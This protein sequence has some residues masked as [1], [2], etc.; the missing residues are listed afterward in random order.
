MA[1][2]QPFSGIRNAKIESKAHWA[3]NR[4]F[5]P[6]QFQDCGRDTGYEAPRTQMHTLLSDRLAPGKRPVAMSDGPFMRFSFGKSST[7]C[8][9]IVEQPNDRQQKIDRVF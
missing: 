6:N 1:V 7:Q 8:V 5:L 9:G 4:E 2:M 3:T